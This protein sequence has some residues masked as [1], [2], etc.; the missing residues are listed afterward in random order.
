[1]LPGASDS[2]SVTDAEI[3]RLA[4]AMVRY[5]RWQA[6]RAQQKERMKFMKRIARKESND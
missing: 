6:A 5:Q 2:G 3:G 1:V 4:D